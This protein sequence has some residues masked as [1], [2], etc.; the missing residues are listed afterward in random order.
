[1]GSGSSWPINLSEPG[2]IGFCPSRRSICHVALYSDD[3]ILVGGHSPRI[4]GKN[5]RC[6]ST[7]TDYRNRRPIGS[8][9]Y[10]RWNIPR[11]RTVVG[12]PP[13]VS[14]AQ[15]R[16]RL[17]PLQEAHNTGILS[18]YSERS[19]VG[20][21]SVQ[22]MHARHSPMKALRLPQLSRAKRIWPR[23]VTM[24][25]SSPEPGTAP[26]C[27]RVLSVRT[28]TPATRCS[29]TCRH[30]AH[31][32]NSGACSRIKDVPRPSSR[33]VPRRC[34]RPRRGSA[35]GRHLARRG[36]P[37]RRRGR[38]ARADRAARPRHRAQAYVRRASD[39]RR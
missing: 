38:C 21:T 16:K 24:A 25:P 19:S 32:P 10:I 36:R 2:H 1:M 26:F 14:S 22:P 3:H 34:G 4:G 39:G 18:A 31:Q 9:E 33:R 23:A 7:E 27:L 13:V 5:D 30:T 37:C 8:L 28:R 15:K 35:L 6:E 11:I 12:V 20:V 17:C 29:T